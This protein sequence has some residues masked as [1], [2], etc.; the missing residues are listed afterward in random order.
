MEFVFI[1]TAC[2]EGGSFEGSITL[3]MMPYAER[4]RTIARCKFELTA[5]GLKEKKSESLE[6]I[7]SLIEAV[8][9]YIVKVEIK[10]IE[11]GKVFSSYD[12][13]SF[14]PICDEILMELGMQFMSGFKLGN[15]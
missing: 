9:K 12:E 15:G 10:H 5:E 14:D 8:S 6:A 2:K 7:A 3:K 4:L 1:P 13:M 11:S